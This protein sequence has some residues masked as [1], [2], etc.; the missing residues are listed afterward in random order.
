VHVDAPWK[1]MIKMRKNKA[2]SVECRAFHKEANAL[3]VKMRMT[4]IRQAQQT[5][6]LR[7]SERDN[8]SASL[9]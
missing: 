1:E 3:F 8:P 2:Q 5:M 7:V 4:A 9:A 6:E